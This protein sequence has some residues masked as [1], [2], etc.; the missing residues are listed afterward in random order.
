[1]GTRDARVD[2]Y[3]AKAAPFARPILEHLR[4]LVHATC[5][6]AEESIKWSAPFFLYRGGMFCHMAAFKQ[7]CAFGFWKWKQV[8]GDDCPKTRWA[9]S[10]ASKNCPTCRRRKS[11]PRI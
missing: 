5:P 9:S 1:M 4:E 11:S 8:V 2:A 3:I 6:Q 7:H 10:A